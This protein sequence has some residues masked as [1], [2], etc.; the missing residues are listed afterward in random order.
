MQALTDAHG[1]LITNIYTHTHIN[2]HTHTHAHTHTH[3]HTLCGKYT[4]TCMCMYKTVREKLAT[5]VKVQKISE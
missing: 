2:T 4:D 1:G 5:G 3:T